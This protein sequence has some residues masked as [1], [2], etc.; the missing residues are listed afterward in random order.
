M[1]WNP[2]NAVIGKRPVRSENRA[3]SRNLEDGWRVAYM[4]VVVVV[5]EILGEDQVLRQAVGVGFGG[6]V[7]WP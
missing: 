3:S 2:S 7:S 4:F 5:R 6:A 1:Y